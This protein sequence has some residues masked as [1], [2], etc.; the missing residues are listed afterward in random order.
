MRA[1]YAEGGG[2]N[3]DGDWDRIWELLRTREVR[4]PLNMREKRE[5]MRK[6]VVEGTRD[7]DG[8]VTPDE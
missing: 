2:A 1:G 5:D 4:E 3:E 7:M 6:S 8:S